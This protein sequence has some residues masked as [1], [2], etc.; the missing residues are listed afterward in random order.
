MNHR[1]KTIVD[2]VPEGASVLDLGAAKLQENIEDFTHHHIREKAAYC[3]GLDK[4]AEAIEKLDG[5]DI[6][7]ADV[8]DFELE[9]EFDVVVAGELI[10][11]LSQPGGMIECA[12]S[13]LKKGGLF[14]LSTPY[15]WMFLRLRQNL[16]DF[17]FVPGDHVAWY[18]PKT[19][20]N[21]LNRSG[22]SKEHVILNQ[23]RNVGISW[24]LFNIGIK[25]FGAHGFVFVAR[26]SS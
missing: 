17:P 22:F 25:R 14:I 1:I 23:P 13:H 3:V 2:C 4:D 15:P 21:M 18:C 7:Q 6:Y 16:F 24:L 19:L 11:H 9:E 20:D 8:Q 10:E 12:H 5:Y 26:K